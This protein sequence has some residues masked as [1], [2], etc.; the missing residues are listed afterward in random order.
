MLA[1]FTLPSGPPLDAVSVNGIELICT[2]LL[3][4]GGYQYGFTATL[5]LRIVISGEHV[6]ARRTP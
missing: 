5:K 3:V 1:D 4:S 2:W 6:S